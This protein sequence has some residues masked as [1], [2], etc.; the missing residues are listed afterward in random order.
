MKIIVNF[1]GKIL[2]YPADFG[3]VFHARACHTLQ[4]TKMPRCIFLR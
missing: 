1:L 4:S 2:I 3:K